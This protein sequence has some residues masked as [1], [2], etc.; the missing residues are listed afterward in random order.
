MGGKRWKGSISAHYEV[1]CLL[2]MYLATP[3]QSA[4]VMSTHTGATSTW[5]CTWPRET[6]VVGSVTSVSTTPWAAIANSASRFTTATHWL[7]SV[8]APLASVSVSLILLMIY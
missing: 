1:R 7:T 3:P 2:T 8:P 4:T 5:P 6:P